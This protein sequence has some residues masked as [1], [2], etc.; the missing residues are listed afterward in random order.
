MSLLGEIHKPKQLN[1]EARG[2]DKSHI[3]QEILN[4]FADRKHYGDVACGMI[5]TF[6][7]SAVDFVKAHSGRIFQVLRNPLAKLSVRVDACLVRGYRQPRFVKAYTNYYGRPPLTEMDQVEAVFL[8]N[9]QVVY[10]SILSRAKKYGYPIVRLEDINYSVGT[11][12]RFFKKLMEWLTQTEWSIHYIERIR[13][14]VQPNATYVWSFQWSEG[15]S[16]GRP[17]LE[18]ISCRV[19]EPKEKLSSESWFVDLASMDAWHQWDGE[20]YERY[21][22]HFAG[23]EKVLGYNQSYPGSVKVEWEYRNSYCWGEPKRKRVWKCRK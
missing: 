1:F 3:D 8:R 9:A 14:K 11:E 19:D 2:L 7:R 15:E 5:K 13:E 12:G 17:R 4:Y 16:V 20:V 23:I 18:L 10:Q 6:R 21:M 22:R